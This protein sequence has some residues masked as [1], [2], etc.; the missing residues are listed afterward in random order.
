MTTNILK[1]WGKEISVEPGFWAVL[2]VFSVVCFVDGF[3]GLI[4]ANSFIYL[5]VRIIAIFLMM[6][7]INI[8]NIGIFEWIYQNYSN[9]HKS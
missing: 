4:F 5:P 1:L 8:D 6:L 7:N 2:I 9:E 3:F